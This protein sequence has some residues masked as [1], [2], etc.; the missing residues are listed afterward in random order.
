MVLGNRRLTVYGTPWCGDCRRA[1]K[2]LGEQP[3]PYRPHAV[4]ADADPKRFFAHYF[5]VVVG[6]EEHPHAYVDIPDLP[7]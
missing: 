5:D 6:G 7:T 4:A 2:F 1:K 3:I